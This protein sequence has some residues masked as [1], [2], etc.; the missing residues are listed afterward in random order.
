MKCFWSAF[1]DGLKLFWSMFE[2]V[3]KFGHFQKRCK[4]TK[5]KRHMQILWQKKDYNF[6]FWRF[7]SIDDTNFALIM[8]TNY[9]QKLPSFGL[10]IKKMHFLWRQHS[11]FF[12]PI[13]AKM[14]GR[15]LR[16]AWPRRARCHPDPFGIGFKG[17]W[18]PVKKSVKSSM[19][20]LN[21]SRDEKPQLSSTTK[22]KTKL[23]IL[24]RV[25]L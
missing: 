6:W 14:R 3:L 20:W 17:I 23:T 12:T 8:T 18:F 16:L 9:M 4:D 1:E 19:W 22:N 7:S 24:V 10:S 5:N 13:S 25:Y 2:V 21:R 15:I 11:I